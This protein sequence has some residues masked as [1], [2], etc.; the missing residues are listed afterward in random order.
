MKKN[1]IFIALL[2]TASCALS[3][4]KREDVKISKEHLDKLTQQRK[5]EKEENKRLLDELAQQLAK[6]NKKIV[7]LYELRTMLLSQQLTQKDYG[8]IIKKEGLCS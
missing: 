1:I 6:Q 2:A 5:K 3:M 7:R 4:E 8:E